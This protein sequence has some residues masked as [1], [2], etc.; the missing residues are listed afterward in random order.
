MVVLVSTAVCTVTLLVIGILG[1]V[2]KTLP[3]QNFL[4]FVACVWSF[5]NVARKIPSSF[6][7]GGISR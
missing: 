1:F 3:L 2:P 5:F 6:S 7:L 4:I